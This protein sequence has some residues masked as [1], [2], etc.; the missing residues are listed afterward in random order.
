MQ[1]LAVVPDAGAQVV[2]LYDPALVEFLVAALWESDAWRAADVL[3]RVR[4]IA[5][6][7]RG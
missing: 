6:C 7:K 5:C 3:A 4:T 1:A 2:R